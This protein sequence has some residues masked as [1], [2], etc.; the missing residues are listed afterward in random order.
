MFLRYKFFLSENCKRAEE[1]AS[2]IRERRKLD[3]CREAEQAQGK[4]YCL[5]VKEVKPKLLN[6]PQHIMADPKKPRTSKNAK[7]ECET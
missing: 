5:F 2:F 4:E 1:Y 6:E 7:A 3:D